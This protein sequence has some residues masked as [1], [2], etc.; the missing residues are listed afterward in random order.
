MS[1]F[2]IIVIIFVVGGIIYQMGKS[3]NDISEIP[4]GGCLGFLSLLT[5]TQVLLP[6]VLVLSLIIGLLKSCS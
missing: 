2:A 5:I 1:T 4:K 3:N 6:I